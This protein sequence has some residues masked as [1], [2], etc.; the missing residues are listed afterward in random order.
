MLLLYVVPGDAKHVW[1]FN[2]HLFNLP[3]KLLS[4]LWGANLRP[5]LAM[6]PEMEYILGGLLELRLPI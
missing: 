4:F 1:R 5:F 6:N 3:Q 2:A